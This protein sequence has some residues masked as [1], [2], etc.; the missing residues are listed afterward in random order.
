[1]NPPQKR[2][3][4]RSRKRQKTRGYQ[5]NPYP[6]AMEMV[7]YVRNNTQVILDSAG[8]MFR[9]INVQD[10]ISATDFTS[11]A[12]IY[13][14]YKVLRLSTWFIPYCAVTYNTAAEFE[15]IY[16]LPYHSNLPTGMSTG[17]AVEVIEGRWWPPGFNQF[18]KQTW[19]MNEQT[20]NENTFVDVTTASGFDLGG[21]LWY[22]N[23]PTAKNGDPV[24]N[25]ISTFKV[26]FRG[27]R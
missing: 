21:I 22:M 15:T 10:V 12:N 3:R 4:S 23:G 11:F 9:P 16:A 8:D 14:E 6:Q 2:Y 25:I 20:G 18:M 24:G 13:Q 17:Q 26:I 7:H 5:L 1:M 27:R 19:S